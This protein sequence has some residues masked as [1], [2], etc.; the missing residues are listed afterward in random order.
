MIK[1]IVLWRLKESGGGRDRAANAAMIKEKL[2]GLNG[3]IP[4]MIRLE[5]GT[6]FSATPD[7]SHLALY[8]EFKDRAALEG[9]LAHPEHKAVMPF[10]AE[11]RT[12]RR[13]ADY[14]T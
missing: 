6:D 11:A 3:R 4:G 8:S 12:E 10:I 14:E 5:V 1:H 2:E 13:V 9:Y 7:S